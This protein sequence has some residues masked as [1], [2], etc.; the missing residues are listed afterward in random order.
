MKTIINK[1]KAI[2]E[3]MLEYIGFHYVGYKVDIEI[4]AKEIKAIKDELKA[5]KNSRIV[6]NFNIQFDDINDK[7]INIKKDVDVA[8]CEGLINK[9]SIENIKDSLKML[10]GD[11]KVN[12]NNID[13]NYTC[14]ENLEDNIQSIENRL[15]YEMDFINE[16]Q[17]HEAF[18]DFKHQENINNDNL[19][20]L[21]KKVEKIDNDLN[22]IYQDNL[23]N[24]DDYNKRLHYEERLE[25]LG[26]DDEGDLSGYN[27]FK[28]EQ[29][30]YFNSMD[31]F[32][33]QLIQDKKEKAVIKHIKDM[34]NNNKKHNELIEN[35]LNEM[36]ELNNLKEDNNND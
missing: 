21:K 14:I 26:I 17:L 4:N 32:E 13:S 33:T 30:I 22:D 18:Y 19:Y 20:E 36:C 1:I 12:K 2:F 11:I 24:D 35:L 3:N 34:L 29:E 10:R 23:I 25:G 15:D 31:K 9:D 28:K 6:E 5:L 8:R 7:L 27:E 16:D